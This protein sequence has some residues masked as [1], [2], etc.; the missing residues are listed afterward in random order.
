MIRPVL[1]SHRKQARECVR[2]DAQTRRTTRWRRRGEDEGEREKG[3]GEE[4]RG[5]EARGEEGEEE[6]AG[7][8]AVERRADT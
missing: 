7:D 6:K 1:V 4:R 5:G 3:R 8:P 2:D